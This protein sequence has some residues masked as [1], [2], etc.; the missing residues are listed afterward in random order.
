MHK[1][2]ARESLD[3]LNK[4]FKAGGI[5]PD[6]FDCFGIIYSHLKKHIE[7]PE[8]FNGVLLSSYAD[9]FME[10]S[11]EALENM[12]A[13]LD[14]CCNRESFPLAGDILLL[15][16]EDIWVPALSAGDGNV[17]T[18][19]ISKGVRVFKATKI[20]NIIIIWRI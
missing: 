13:F 10:D 20:F 12:I 14:S 11:K 18:S 3:Y 17:I 7:V 8:E 15:Q 6:A 16:Q 1:T 4:P 5:G 9:L 2:F 19:F